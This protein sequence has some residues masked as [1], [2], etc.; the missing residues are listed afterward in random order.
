MSDTDEL[1]IPPNPEVVSVPVALNPQF[2][3]LMILF[4]ENWTA[5]T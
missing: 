3:K 2:D 1:I 4:T 5:W